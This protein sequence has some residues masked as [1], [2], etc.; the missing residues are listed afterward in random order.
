[1]AGGLMTK[2]I[3]PTM[4]GDTKKCPHCDRW[5]RLNR[6]SK[7][8]NGHG[9]ASWC[10]DCSAAIERTYKRRN[11][12]RIMVTNLNSGARK[13]GSTAPYI[14]WSE[15]QKRYNEVGQICYICN[16][17]IPERYVSFNHVIPM[18]RGGKHAMGNL[19]P[20]HIGCNHAKNDLPLSEVLNWR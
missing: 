11:P 12:F 5:R 8:S 2:G 16:L 9:Y 15:L 19:M 13:R 3:F 20:S 10:K 4:R 18:V 17:L 14:H 6:F 1:M 7:R